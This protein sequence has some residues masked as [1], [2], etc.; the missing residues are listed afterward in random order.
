MARNA[1][2]STKKYSQPSRSEPR[3]A[4]VVKETEYLMSG[5]VFRT[6]SI[7]V[8]LPPPEGELTTM[9][10]P[11]PTAGAETSVFVSSFDILHLFPEFLNF[12]FNRQ[13]GV[14]DGD[15]SRLREDGVRFT[16]QFL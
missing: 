15:L 9:S 11:R 14:F 10:M 6:R 12:G 5:T 3:G 4:R 8:P 13:P 16:I 2:S 7:R 1:G